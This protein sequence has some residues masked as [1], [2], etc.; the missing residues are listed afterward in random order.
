MP[1][2]E[3][4]PCRTG[5][6]GHR[7][8]GGSSR[9]QEE[10]SC[11]RA[12]EPSKLLSS[13]L[14][15][16]LN[17]P[18]LSNALSLITSDL[19]QGELLS[20][21]NERMREK[22]DE[23]VK[24]EKKGGREGAGRDRRRKGGERGKEKEWGRERRKERKKERKKI[25]RKRKKIEKENKRRGGKDANTNTSTECNRE[26][27]KQDK[28]CHAFLAPCSSRANAAQFPGAAPRGDP[29]PARPGFLS[30]SR[31]RTCG[32]LSVRLTQSLGTFEMQS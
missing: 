24:G 7:E 26:K 12:L 17:L 22:E 28:S 10:G 8:G 19:L 20:G 30:H 11:P 27:I 13:F 16:W 23:R 25:K 9:D 5:R 14:S 31:V 1:P 18:L 2:K 29:S 21:K 32:A 15:L 6:K 3:A 4:S